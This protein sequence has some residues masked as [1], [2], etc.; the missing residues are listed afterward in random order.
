[1]LR[2]IRSEQSLAARRER[3]EKVER[4]VVHA[5]RQFSEVLKKAADV[6]EARR[7]ERG[8]YDK[9]EKFLERTHSTP[10]ARR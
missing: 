2:F 8:G 7:L 6:L 10:K 9:Q 4:A 3:Q 1:M 5:F